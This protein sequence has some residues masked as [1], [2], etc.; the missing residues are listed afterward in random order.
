[1]VLGDP[2]GRVIWPPKELRQVGD[3]LVGKGVATKP[4]KL[5]PTPRTPT[6]ERELALD[7][8]SSALVAPIQSK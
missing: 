8:H 2:F 7:L 5:R 1:M 4:M 3:Y 6:A